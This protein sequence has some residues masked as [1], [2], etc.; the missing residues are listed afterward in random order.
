VNEHKFFNSNILLNFRNEDTKSNEIKVFT[1]I[2]IKKLG[3][4]LKK[5][6]KQN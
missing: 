1:K 2:E 5:N 3:L 4:V 6:E